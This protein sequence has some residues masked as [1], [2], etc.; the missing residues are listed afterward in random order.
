MRAKNPFL[1]ALKPEGIQAGKSRGLYVI[2]LRPF[3]INCVV[4][5]R[6]NS[7]RYVWRPRRLTFS[8]VCFSSKDSIRNE[9]ADSTHK[10]YF[11]WP[12]RCAIYQSWRRQVYLLQ[13]PHLLIRPVMKSSSERRS[14]YSMLLT[15][16]PSINQLP[17]LLIEGKPSI[18]AYFP[19]IFTCM[20]SHVLSLGHSSYLLL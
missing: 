19:L 11:G 5:V 18:S 6:Q 1:T 4:W 8:C 15:G 10:I 14:V 12:Q 2:S 13:V 7:K 17:V 16:D 9:G 20:G 3:E